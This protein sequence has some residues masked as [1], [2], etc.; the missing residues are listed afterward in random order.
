M[1]ISPRQYA[2]EGAHHLSVVIGYISVNANGAAEQYVVC[3]FIY[4][5][6]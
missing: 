5:F 4:L 2:R 3:Y 6:C 1:H